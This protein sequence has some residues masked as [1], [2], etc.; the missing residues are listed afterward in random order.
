MLRNTSLFALWMFGVLM[1]RS[2]GM[3]QESFHKFPVPDDHWAYY[4]VTSLMAEG[5]LEGYP[6][7]TFH[8]RR[9]LTRD[10]FAVAMM[11]ASLA[12]GNHYGRNTPPAEPV[13]PI[14]PK[15]RYTAQERE[16]RLLQLAPDFYAFVPKDHWAYAAMRELQEAGLWKRF[17]FS[18]SFD[19]SIEL[20]RSAFAVMLRRVHETTPPGMEGLFNKLRDEFRIEIS[21]LNQV[22]P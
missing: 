12:L 17:G 20:K 21:A 10:E 5:I 6:D 22:E 8:G 4:A 1:V 9:A 13:K 16:A 3:A 14:A 7:G 2:P 19:G 18:T 11:R 15:E